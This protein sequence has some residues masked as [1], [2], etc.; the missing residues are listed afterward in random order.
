MYTKNMQTV[1]ILLCSVVFKYKPILLVA[2]EYKKL[3]M[4]YFA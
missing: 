1:R 4:E 2:Y 3:L